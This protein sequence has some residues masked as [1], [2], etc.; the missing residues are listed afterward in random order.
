[1]R[2]LF[3][4]TC[5]RRRRNVGRPQWKL[6]AAAGNAAAFFI[7]WP[8]AWESVAGVLGAVLLITAWARYCPINRLFGREAA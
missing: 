4:T 8:N 3:A 5:V 2:A 6:Y 1:V 7:E